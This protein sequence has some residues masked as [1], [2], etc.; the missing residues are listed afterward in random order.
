VDCLVVLLVA[1]IAVLASDSTRQKQTFQ[2]KLD[3][4]E[5]SFDR[6]KVAFKNTRVKSAEFFDA[7]ADTAR[8]GMYTSRPKS[9]Q[10]V[11]KG[12]GSLGEAMSKRFAAPTGIDILIVAK[13]F[14]ITDYVYVF[15]AA[16]GINPRYVQPVSKM[17]A[18]LDVFEKKGEQ[19]IP[20]CR[21]DTVFLSTSFV[22]K[23]APRMLTATLELIY[24]SID[25]ALT[26]NVYAKRKPFDRATVYANYS[27]RFEVP[28][29]SNPE[30]YKGVFDTYEQFKQNTPGSQSFT[31]KF[32]KNEPHALYMKDDKGNE[33]LKRKV[34]GVCDGENVYVM[35][36]GMLFQLYKQDKAFYWFGAKDIRTRS[37]GAP[38][39]VPLGGGWFAVGLE[40]VANDVKIIKGPY[41]LN[42]E[43]GEPY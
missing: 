21:V 11:I 24:S 26:K 9:T 36:E 25:D 30:L 14:W 35:Q 8:I 28:V 40:D 37:Y 43:T 32:N 23:V 20:L 5:I 16:K 1:S 17:I 38:A 12:G 29:V 10:I 41:L 6:I 2:Q 19:F 7:R 13:E 18:N 22:P 42:I 31:I 39:A 34:W 4:E 33:F 15:D 27:K 3:S